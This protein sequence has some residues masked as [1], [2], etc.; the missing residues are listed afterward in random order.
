MTTTAK[1]PTVTV[2]KLIGTLH[3]LPDEARDGYYA[4][5]LKPN[6]ALLSSLSVNTLK[7]VQEKWDWSAAP[8]YGLYRRAQDDKMI[9]C[10]K[11]ETSGFGSMVRQTMDLPRLT[12]ETTVD[13]SPVESKQ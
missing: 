6:G 4:T 7:E 10:L 12:E 1:F 8:P 13:W 5:L 2:G 3:T 11:L 9:E